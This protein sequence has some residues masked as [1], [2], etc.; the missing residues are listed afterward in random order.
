MIYIS[1]VQSWNISY[2][3]AIKEFLQPSY[4][5]Q[6]FY[7]FITVA[8]VFLLHLLCYQL[9]IPPNKESSNAQIFSQSKSSNQPLVLCNIVCIRKPKLNCILQGGIS[10]TP[11]LA[12][13]KVYDPL[14]YI[15]QWLGN[16]SMPR[17]PESVHYAMKS[18]SA[19]DL[20]ARL[21]TNSTS[22]WPISTAHYATHPVASLL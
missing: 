22:Y 6:I 11:A 3:K 19:W 18:A 1:V 14:K 2:L 13:L 21:G 10:T 12:P 8:V 4:F 5:R 20:I 9:S 17:K 15:T 16:S 7:H